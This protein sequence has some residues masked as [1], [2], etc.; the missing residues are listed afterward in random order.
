MQ[1][2]I[3]TIHFVSTNYVSRYGFNVTW[4]SGKHSYLLYIPVL[5]NDNNKNKNKNNNDDDDNDDDDDDDDNEYILNIF[6][7]ISF[8]LILTVIIVATNALNTFRY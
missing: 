2:P 8:N 7:I 6:S 5:L 1:T 3:V 4:T